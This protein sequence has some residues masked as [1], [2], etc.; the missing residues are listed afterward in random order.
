M[1]QIS[2]E[3]SSKI[4]NMGFLCAILVVLRHVGTIP[5]KGNALWWTVKFFDGLTWI[6]VPFFF[7]MSGFFLARH[8]DD[9]DGWFVGEFKKRI[10]TLLVPFLL[11]NFLFIVWF[12]ALSNGARLLGYSIH[13]QPVRLSCLLGWVNTLGLNPFDN[14]PHEHLWYLRTLLLFTL[15]SPLIRRFILRT[16]SLGWMVAVYGCLMVLRILSLGY[17][18]LSFV[19]EF[20]CSL[21]GLGFFAFGAYLSYTS[22]SVKLSSL[23]SVGLIVCG[24]IFF[25]T[26]AFCLYVGLVGLGVVFLWLGVPATLIGLWRFIPRRFVLGECTRFAFP[27]YVLH[28]FIGLVIA[29]AIGAIGMRSTVLETSVAL[30]FARWFALVLSTL[31][32]VRIIKAGVPRFYR[33]AFAGRG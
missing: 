32:A 4:V 17:Y 20:T 9:G 28:G 2:Q 21:Q 27:L 26:R 15:V 6:A 18:D 7:L 12:F 19:A 13:I 25:G 29:G 31:F 5:A 8:F 3:T 23:Q 11:W 33:F 30:Y 16:Q 1:K 24:L 14:G 22:T 10:R